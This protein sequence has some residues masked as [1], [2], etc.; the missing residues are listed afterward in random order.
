LQFRLQSAEGFE[1]SSDV[2]RYFSPILACRCLTFEWCGALNV[3]ELAKNAEYDLDIDFQEMLA[4]LMHY[5]A[6]ACIV[7]SM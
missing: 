5:M 4:L 6:E 1:F 7:M 3:S 2:L